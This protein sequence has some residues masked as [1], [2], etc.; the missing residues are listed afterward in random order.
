LEGILNE[1]KSLFLAYGFLLFFGTWGLHRFYLGK[2]FSGLFYLLTCGIFG[3]G[4]VYDFFALPFHV[5]AA[6]S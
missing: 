4:V 3:L 5:C 6:N 2:P 1:K